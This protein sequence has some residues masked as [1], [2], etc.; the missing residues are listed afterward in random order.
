MNSPS[1]DLIQFTDNYSND[2]YSYA[3][4]VEGQY[5]TKIMESLNLDAATTLLEPAIINNEICLQN[6]DPP[7]LPIDHSLF[8]L[9]PLAEEQPGEISFLDHFILEENFDAMELPIAPPT[10]FFDDLD[11]DDHDDKKVEHAGTLES[12]FDDFSADVKYIW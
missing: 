6:R 9:P 5:S 1:L 12:I 7:Q 8:D 3:P 10:T 2:Q 4:Y 11:F